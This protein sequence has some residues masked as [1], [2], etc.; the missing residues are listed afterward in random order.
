MRVCG[1]AMDDQAEDVDQLV[2]AHLD[3]ALD[4]ASAERLH[5]RLRHDG[6][7]RRLLVAAATQASALPRLALEAGLARPRGAHSR[8]QRSAIWGWPL[9]GAL[10]ASLLITWS[11][12]WWSSQS[13][14][15]DVR[16]DGAVALS[17]ERAG[18]RHAGG[19]DPWL[20]PGDRIVVAGGPA[21]LSWTSE[22]TSIELISGTQLVIDALGA[23]KRLRLEQGSLHAE[24]AP[25]SP[26]G[27]LMVAT[28]FGAVDVVG[29]R[30]RVQVQEHTSTV[31]VEHGSVRV[32]TTADAPPL[33]LAAGYQVTV[34]GKTVSSPGPLADLPTPV[35]LPTAPPR[36]RVRLSAT[37]FRPDAGWEGDLVDGTIRARAVPGTN[38]QRITTPLQRPAGYLTLAEDFRCT[39]RVTVDQ[40][41]T[42]AVLLVCDHPDGGQVWVGNLQ[43]ERRIPAGTQELTVTRA[44]LRQVTGNTAPLLGSRVVAVAVMCWMP[45]ADLRLHWLELSR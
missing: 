25:Q 35:L 40:E 23:H 42:L 29:T 22:G 1:V 14:V 6:A 4:A 36:D 10:A 9:A 12:V 31:A 28:P 30:F 21:R 26:A 11:F 44:D 41:T 7:A 39:L 24:V 45:T 13:T 32:T 8:S 20:R 16:I 17:I 3:D 18:K 19:S 37:D 33:L 38:V 27:G 15:G 2:V 43:S 5:A 34:D